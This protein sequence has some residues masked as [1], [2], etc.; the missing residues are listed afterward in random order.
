MLEVFD[1]LVQDSDLL[2]PTVLY[3]FRY[4]E[5][6]INHHF[7]I[8]NALC[9]FKNGSDYAADQLQPSMDSCFPNNWKIIAFEH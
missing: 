2:V 6:R 9:T 1:F 7:S 3:L 4:S 5:G 8:I